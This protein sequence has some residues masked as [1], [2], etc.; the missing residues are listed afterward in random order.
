MGC[1]ERWWGGGDTILADVRMPEKKE[2]WETIDRA[3][4]RR[5][6]QG[7]HRLLSESDCPPLVLRKRWI[8]GLLLS[9]MDNWQGP[10]GPPAPGLL[11]RATVRRTVN[12]SSLESYSRVTGSH[13]NWLQSQNDLR[14]KQSNN[15]CN[16]TTVTVWS[17]KYHLIQVELCST[18]LG[19]RYLKS[20]HLSARG[21][22]SSLPLQKLLFIYCY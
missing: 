20:F 5:G 8:V 19:C 16:R 14:K 7:L 13:P 9:S 17:Y 4:G 6:A 10:K 11:I 1:W 22:S 3:G 2:N 12:I 15:K 18:G 21:I